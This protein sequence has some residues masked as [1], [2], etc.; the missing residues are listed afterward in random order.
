MADPFSV[1][2]GTA[3]LADVCV[4]LTKFIKQANAGFRTVDE[5]LN[6]LFEEIVSLQSINELVKRSFTDGFSAKRAPNYEQILGSH[7]C[8]TQNT[9]AS[10]QRI[11]EQLET[12]LIEVLNAESG[13]HVK[14]DQLRKWLKQQSKEE[15][16]SILRQKLKAHQMALQL[17]LSAISVSVVP[18]PM[19]VVN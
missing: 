8:A 9:L 14:L 17:S 7:W 19:L 12:L 13:R 1:L 16:F 4:R 2:A 18:A 11:V 3:G 5:D 6:D 10:C 15:A